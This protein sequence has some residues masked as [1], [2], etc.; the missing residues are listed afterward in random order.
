LRECRWQ[1]DQ[2]P[3]EV[4]DLVIEDQR[5]RNPICWSVFEA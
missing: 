5:R 3:E 2:L 1:R 4:R